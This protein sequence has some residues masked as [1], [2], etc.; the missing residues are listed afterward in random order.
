MYEQP[1]A[2]VKHYEVALELAEKHDADLLTAQALR[3]LGYHARAAGDL[4]QAREQLIRSTE[5]FQ[6][7]GHLRPTLASKPSS[8][9]YSTPK[10]TPPV[11]KP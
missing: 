7:A 3:H 4:V 1:T 9:N 6:K 10:A 8:P 11:P 5:L 2:A